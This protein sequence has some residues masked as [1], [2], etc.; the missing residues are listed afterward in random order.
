[1][2]IQWRRDI[3][4]KDVFSRGFYAGLV[5][6]FVMATGSLLS[7]FLPFPHLRII[8]WMAIM[9]FAHAPSFTVLETGIAVLANIFFGG[10]LGIGFSFMITLIKSERIYLKGWVFSLTVWISIYVVTTI[11]KVTGTVPTSVETAI[12]NVIG[13]SI[14]GFTLAYA[15]KKLLYGE[16]ESS[17]R[18][19]MA[20]AMKPL[21]NREDKDK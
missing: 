10:I 3:L 19:N 1:M 16:T 21:R 8:D 7:D 17:Y 15:T 11:Y 5:A 13:S 14:Y 18:M 9:I 6:G 20:P 12:A 2:F 4:E